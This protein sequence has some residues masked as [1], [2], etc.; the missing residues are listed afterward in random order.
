MRKKY[1]KQK[2]NEKRLAFENLQDKRDR[3][4]KQKET[5]KKTPNKVCYITLFLGVK[6]DV[7]QV[8]PVKLPQ[9]ATGIK[10]IRKNTEKRLAA[11]LL[12]FRPKNAR[13]KAKKLFW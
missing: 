6:Q 7:S 1:V 12:V 10:G 2:E 4:T 3:I 13:Q 9:I 11:P 8:A 5:S